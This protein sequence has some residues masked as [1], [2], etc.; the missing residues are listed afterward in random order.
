LRS[1]SAAAAANF[2]SAS[3]SSKSAAIR[4]FLMLAEERADV[5]DFGEVWPDL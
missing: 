1:A 5:D 3:A 4:R 2:I